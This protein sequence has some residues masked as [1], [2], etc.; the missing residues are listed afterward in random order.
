[1]AEL[2]RLERDLPQYLEALSSMEDREWHAMS[3]ESVPQFP[4]IRHM[5]IQRMHA[6]MHTRGGAQHIAAL[7]RHVPRRSRR[8]WYS[9]CRRGA[10]KGR[11]R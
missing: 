4:P 3:P 9:P 8:C 7:L 11:G 10:G 2:R 6:C 1:M 5:A